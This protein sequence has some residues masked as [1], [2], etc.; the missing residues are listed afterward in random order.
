MEEPEVQEKIK[1]E[2]VKKVKTEPGLISTGEGV[3]YVWY[4]RTCIRTYIRTYIHTYYG[5]PLFFRRD[6]LIP[7]LP[8]YST[9]ILFTPLGNLLFNLLLNFRVFYIFL[10]A[11]RKIVSGL[12]HTF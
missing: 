6:N 9:P 3:L 10:G 4:V 7:L 1:D 5:I 11:F 8:Y 2:I 12:L